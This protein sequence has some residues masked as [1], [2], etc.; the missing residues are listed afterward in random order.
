[1]EFFNNGADFVYG[2][3]V[4]IRF[5]IE[6]K[7]DNSSWGQTL[8]DDAIAPTF[9]FANVAVFDT[10]FVDHVISKARDAIAGKIAI[11]QLLDQG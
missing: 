9:A 10:D 8:V 1:M 3:V 2:Y 5:G 4:L 11:L 7:E 6:V